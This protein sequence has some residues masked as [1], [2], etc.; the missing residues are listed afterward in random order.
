VAGVGMPDAVLVFA[1]G[2]VAD[3]V[4][5]ILDMPV[6]PPPAPQRSGVG[7]IGTQA[8]D[9]VSGLDR[10]FAATSHASREPAHLRQARPVEPSG[11][12]GGRLQTVASATA[13]PFVGG[14]NDFAA[15]VMLT[16]RVGGKSPREIR[17]R[18]GR[19]ARADC[20]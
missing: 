11:Q 1:E 19:A 2:R 6:I 16:L 5:P 17:R 8:G 4:K 9:G 7:L 13:V 10:L 20:L 14:F 12:P 18:T 15:G 3:P